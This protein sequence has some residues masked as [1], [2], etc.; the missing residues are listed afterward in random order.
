MATPSKTGE[1][2]GQ[3]PRQLTYIVDATRGPLVGAG[4]I[5][6]G[7]PF[8]IT[9]VLSLMVAVPA[10]AWS[11]PWFAALGSVGVAFTIV[12]ALVVPWGQFARPWQLVP[13]VLLLIAT[14][15]LTS[16]EGSGFGS[17][18]VAL[19]VLPLMWLAIYESRRAVMSVGALTGAALWLVVPVDQAAS[20][21]ALVATAVFVI[22]AVGMGITLQSVVADTGQVARALHD[23]RTELERAAMMLDAIPDH[24]SRFR[25]SDH[26]ITYCN[27]AWAGLYHCTPSSAVGQPLDTFLSADEVAGLTAQLALLGP[28]NPVLEDVAPRAVA[29]PPLRWL[30]W[31]DRYLVGEHGDEILSIG[32][33]V[34]A[35][36]T[37]EAELAAS[38]ARYRELADK[39]VDVVWR[40]TLEPTPHFDYMSP[41][42]ES[43]LGY[44]PSY[45]LE[46]FTRMLD[47]LDE[48]SAATIGRAFNGER[49]L[50]HFDCHFRHAD[51][52]TVI[53]ETRTA[54]VS[55][56]LQGVSRNVTELRRLQADVEA[57]A[58]RD[59][60]TGLANR[61]LLEELLDAELERTQRHGLTLAVAFLDLDD[62]KSVNDT[63]GH[64]CGDLV[65]REIA[66][67]LL[68]VGRDADTVARFG[69]D[70][71][72]I[73][74]EPDDSNSEHF[75][76]RM[77]RVLSAPIDLSPTAAVFCRVSIGVADTGHV[78]YDRSALLGEADRA[79]YESKRARTH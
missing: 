31:I 1:L 45:F 63:Y 12:V 41:S 60:L 51:G 13:P 74:F 47:I 21:Q 61:R 8:V 5:R 11:R 36:Y 66:H 65:L 78:G 58:L 69:G 57:L 3:A 37:A 62:F 53:G 23:K 4:R 20:S 22:C 17:P 7:A 26:V 50:E 71:F 24:V 25:L 42:V 18:F 27:V 32:R 55:G 72:V 35:R 79:M 9:S 77:Q 52:S 44:P 39:S 34:T 70:E 67:R 29:H 75:I 10:T 43:M 48:T 73:V 56:G 28:E 33:D 30:H 14:L 59:P 76:D 19:A 54:R 2:L 15:L 64:E 38:E 49:V 6:R 68:S 16:A 46:H 40:F